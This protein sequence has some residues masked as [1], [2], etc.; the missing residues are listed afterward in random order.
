MR[1]ALALALALI[2]A[3][4]LG[5]VTTGTAGAAAPPAP[6]FNGFENPD[7][8][9]S[10][11]DAIHNDSMFNVTRVTSGSGGVTSSSGGFHATAALTSPADLRFT[12]Y[13]GYSSSFP[14]GGY[15]TSVDIYLDMDESAPLEDTRFDWSSAINDNLG[16]HRRDFVFSV[17]TDGLGDFVM[18][19]SNNTPGWPANPGRDPFPITTTGWYTLRHSFHD[20]GSGVLQ[21]DMSVLSG[22]TVLHTWMLSTPSDTIAT[23]GGNR[24]GWLVTSG[25]ASLA[26]DNVTRTTHTPTF[27]PCAVTISGSSPTVYTLLAD[28]VTDHTILVPQHVGGTTF[29]GD[30]HS[31]TGVDPLGDH[32]RGAVVRAQAG[33]ELITVENLTVTVSGLSDSCD[34]GDDRLRGILFDGVAG[35]IMNNEV[36][37]I[38]QGST[39]GCQEG[40]GIEVRNAPFDNTGADLAVSVT[41]N[42]VDAY[43]K[44]GIVAN[45]SVAATISG[46]TV[47]GDGPVNYIA[48]NGIQVGFGATAIVKNNSSSG[49]NYTPK[50]TIACGLLIFDADGVKASS[51]NLFDNERNQCNFGKGGGQFNPVP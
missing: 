38:R 18:S 23:T 49:N 14:V 34:G 51:N 50:D 17:G 2:T 29:D 7:D 30:G 39:S 27:E 3:M 28:C 10:P 19:A 8:A 4:A 33:P 46:N 43:Q 13:G 40:N 16:A 48:Q 47:T 6:H 21:V 26:L 31:I 20:N 1:K 35:S 15:T 9:W 5:I 44:T 11:V 22:A 42:T 32:F 24:Y 12:R 25:F 45:G 41:G 37:G 36:I